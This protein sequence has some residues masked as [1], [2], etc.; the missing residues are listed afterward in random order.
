MRKLEPTNRFKKDYKAIQKQQIFDQQTF[1][2]VVKCLAE[3][4]PLEEKH[5][6]HALHGDFEGARECHIKPDWLLI[7]AKD[8]EG[9]K[10]ILMRTGGHSK[11]FGI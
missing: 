7:Y 5:H 3:D 9:L 2:T 8:A 11:L 4:K 1:N 10:L 6:D